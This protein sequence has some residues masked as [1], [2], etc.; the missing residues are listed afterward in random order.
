[1]PDQWHCKRNTWNP[2]SASYDAPEDKAED[3]QDIG[4]FGVI[5]G[6]GTM[7]LSKLR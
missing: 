5:G 7:S 4:V 3:L 6:V 1:L 2:E